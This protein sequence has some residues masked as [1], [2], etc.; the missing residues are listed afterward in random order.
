[1]GIDVSHYQGEVDWSLV[2]SG[3]VKFA[4]AK[5]TEGTHFTDD[6]FSRNWRHMQEVGLFRGAYHFARPGVETRSRRHRR[7][8]H[9]DGRV[10]LGLV[11]FPD[12]T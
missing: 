3:D 1:M 9:V 5:A 7:T 6:R 8:A 11:R 12:S 10:C 2:A 4:F